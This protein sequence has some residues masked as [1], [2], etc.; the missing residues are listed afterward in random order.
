VGCLFAILGAHYQNWR[1]A[2]G[3]PKSELEPNPSNQP[4]KSHN[5]VC[6]FWRNAFL[7]VFSVSAPKPKPKAKRSGPKTEVN[8]SQSWHDSEVSKHCLNAF[9]AT[10]PLEERWLEI[11]EFR[12]QNFM[13]NSWLICAAWTWGAAFIIFCARES[14]EVSRLL[15]SVGN[16]KRNQGKQIEVSAKFS[17]LKSDAEKK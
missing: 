15:A 1:P 13:Q 5:I 6:L 9:A 4:A 10:H 8:H 7:F 14:R 3:E 16:N 12:M 17:R 2:T 11:W